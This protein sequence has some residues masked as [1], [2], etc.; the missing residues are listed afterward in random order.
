[1]LLPARH[2]PSGDLNLRVPVFDTSNFLIRTGGPPMVHKGLI[3]LLTTSIYSHLTST[4][5][6]VGWKYF[7]G[8]EWKSSF[9]NFES[10]RRVEQLWRKYGNDNTV[11]SSFPSRSENIG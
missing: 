11:Q 8:G 1:M 7:N 5:L 4:I 2:M 10:A 9:I 6:H 3:L